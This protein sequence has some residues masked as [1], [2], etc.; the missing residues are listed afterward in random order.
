MNI[1]RIKVKV[2][3]ENVHGERIKITGSEQAHE[4][5]K[6][7]FDADT[8]AWTEEMILISLNRQN[9]VIG[10]NKISSGGMAGVIVDPKVI[11]SLLLNTSAHGFI[12]AHN[13]P[14]GT[15]NPS[16]ED[17]K[18]TKRLKESGELLDIKLLDH[19]I[20]TPDPDKYLSFADQGLI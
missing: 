20:L 19:L 17:I 16:Q 11:F 12:V 15:T 1:P 10:Y 18:I 9:E 5:C 7:L 2:E 3:I 8:I 13:H 4:V 6:K 14:S